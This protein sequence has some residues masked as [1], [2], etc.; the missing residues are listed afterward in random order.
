MSLA[1]L[2]T[3]L[4]YEIRFCSD[5]FIAAV[6]KRNIYPQSVFVSKLVAMI[7]MDNV[8]VYHIIASRIRVSLG[9][10]VHIYCRVTRMAPRATWVSE[11]FAFPFYFNL[12]GSRFARLCQFLLKK[13]KYKNVHKNCDTLYLIDSLC[14][15]PQNEIRLIRKI[16]RNIYFL[17]PF[18]FYPRSQNYIRREF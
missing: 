8:L 3:F 10:F 7:L 11:G 4:N 12:F 18:N 16:T 5:C 13:K 14:I 17:R 9:M 1:N 15:P 2:L 6:E